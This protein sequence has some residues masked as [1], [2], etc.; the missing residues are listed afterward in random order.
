IV[1]AAK[2]TRGGLYYHFKDKKDLFRAVHEQVEE[3][4]AA[5]IATKLASADHDLIEMLHVGVR[6]F[7]DACMDP[8]VAQIA[9]V[10]AP[11]ILGWKEWR[12]VDERHGLGLI[13]AGLELG[14]AD[15]MLV[16]QPVKPLAHLL[17]GAVGEAGMMIANAPDPTH[18]RKEVQPAL[19]ALVEGL[20]QVDG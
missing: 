20:R 12:E 7:L 19:I 13:I 4:I 1:H 3:R 18:A 16:P 9:L 14:I 6:S 5:G 8:K 2:T 15:G 11:S 10:D 17:L